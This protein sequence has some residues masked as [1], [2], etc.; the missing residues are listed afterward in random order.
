M[1]YSL[2]IVDFIYFRDTDT[3]TYNKRRNLL[4]SKKKKIQS[5]N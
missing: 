2:K 3:H 4:D 1:K 5:D